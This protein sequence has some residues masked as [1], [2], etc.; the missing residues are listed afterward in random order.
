[1][2]METGGWRKEVRAQVRCS[3]CGRMRPWTELGTFTTDFSFELGL[4][5][6]TLTQTVLYCRDASDCRGAAQTLRLIVPGEP[7]A[8]PADLRRGPDSAAD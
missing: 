4:A 3:C 5:A 2:G 8:A 1:M 7:L 6:G